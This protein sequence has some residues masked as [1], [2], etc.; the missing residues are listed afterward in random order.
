MKICRGYS[1][2]GFRFNSGGSSEA[3]GSSL[4]MPDAKLRE[5]LLDSLSSR[6]RV[7]DVTGWL[8]VRKQ[9][10]AARHGGLLFAEEHYLFTSFV[11]CVFNANTSLA[12]KASMA[13]EIAIRLIGSTLP[14]S[15]GE[16]P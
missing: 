10:I 6:N 5:L 9:K 12:I 1:G 15:F 4:G 8:A 14:P 16:R 11:F 3:D 13:R 7:N 2:S